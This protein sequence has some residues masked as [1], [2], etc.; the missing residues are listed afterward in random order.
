AF[1]G[2]RRDRSV[3]FW[4]SMPVSDLTTAGAKA[5]IPLLVLPLVTFAATAV[6]QIL[7]MV[8]GSIRLAA[9]GSSVAALWGQVPLFQMWPM[10]LF[11]LV[12]G[13]GLWYAP[14]YGWFLLVS[15]W[16]RRASLLWATLPLLALALVERIA[17]NT[18]HFATLLVRRFAGSPDTG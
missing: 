3:M 5:A 4:K 12:A 10:L 18:S 11:H 9:D 2:E 6:A 7:M 16:A 13:H 17:F 15:A 8:V 1:Q 14:F